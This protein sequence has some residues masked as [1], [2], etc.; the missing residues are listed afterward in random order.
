MAGFEV[1]VR[2]VV[3]PRIRPAPARSLPPVD[4]PEAGQT[5][6]SGGSGQVI[7][8]THSFSASGSRPGGTETERTY[9]VARVKGKSGGAGAFA[10]LAASLAA[11]G[12]EDAYIDVEVIKRVRML[13]DSG[14]SV[15]NYTPIQESENITIIQRD[16]TRTS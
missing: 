2:P 4:D 1:I 16:Q 5:V 3:F 12:D 6:F 10:A 7:A 9:D 15:Y 14:T 11:T 13:G 8:L